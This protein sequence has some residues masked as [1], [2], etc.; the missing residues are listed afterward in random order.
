MKELTD[1]EYNQ[2]K[3]V[4][5]DLIALERDREL[6]FPTGELHKNPRYVLRQSDEA[7]R[8]L[9]HDPTEVIWEDD[10]KALGIEIEN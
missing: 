8:S 1:E 3:Q 9:D 2:I 7:L 10:R 6:G 4:L 5:I